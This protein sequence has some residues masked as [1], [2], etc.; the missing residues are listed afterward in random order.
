[1][2]I[3]MTRNRFE[4]GSGGTDRIDR[5]RNRQRM[6]A[7][8]LRREEAKRLAPFAFLEDQNTVTRMTF[9]D[10]VHE[11]NIWRSRGSRGKNVQGLVV[12]LNEAK[13]DTLT[14]NDVIAC[15]LRYE[16]SPGY[17][18]EFSDPD[19]DIGDAQFIHLLIA[20]TSLETI[21]GNRD[22]YPFKGVA[23]GQVRQMGSDRVLPLGNLIEQ[24]NKFT[25]SALG[26][27]IFSR[28]AEFS[29]SDYSPVVNQAI[30]AVARD[31]E[32]MRRVEGAAMIRSLNPHINIP[33]QEIDSPIDI[34]TAF[35][36][37]TLARSDGGFTS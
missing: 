6:T 17:D 20:K 15:L 14:P 16:A 10:L 19:I 2:Y 18:I 30:T 27:S 35:D 31:Q 24:G 21:L 25:D 28:N 12:V 11:G 9:K 26:I 23:D 33:L 13:P 7:E 22:G 1:M 36:L 4:S 29:Y 34:N 3:N 37:A 5:I 32:N 8:K